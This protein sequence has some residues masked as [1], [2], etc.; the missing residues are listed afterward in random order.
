[1]G[2]NVAA[3]SSSKTGIVPTRYAAVLLDMAADAGVVEKVEGDIRDLSAMLQSAPDLQAMLSNPLA[4]RER[5]TAVIADIAK[6]AKLQ[7]LTS[8]FLGVLAANNRL[9]MLEKVLIAY[10]NELVRRRGEVSAKVQT[11]FALS[12]EQ[13]QALKEQLGKAMGSNITLDVEVN[14][15]LLGGMVVTVGSKQIDSS[16]KRQ[17]ELLKRAMAQGKAA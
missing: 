8:N 6:Q 5:L 15:D 2:A 13:T 9:G 12:P 17:L 7:T 4:G 14:K 16:V 10:Q 11:A 1:M 3:A